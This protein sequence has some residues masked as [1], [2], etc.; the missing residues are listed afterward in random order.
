MAQVTGQNLPPPQSP[1]VDP[2]TGFLS[3]DGYQYL[4]SLLAAAAA[5][6]ATVTT[7]DGLVATGTNQATALQLT[8]QWNE[9]DTVPAGSGVLL[10]ALQ[11]GQSQ[12]VFNEG[13]NPLNVYPPPGARINALA[14]NAPFP[15]GTGSRATFDFT[16]DTQ[17][18]S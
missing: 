1:F 16:S 14:L 8:S 3:D 17:I 5:D 12:T 11:V 18:R 9:V 4:L 10:S 13:V 6:Q 15:L 2:A 7:S